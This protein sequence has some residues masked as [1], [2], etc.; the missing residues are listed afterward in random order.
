M[1]KYIK[2]LI[3]I[4]PIFFVMSCKHRKSREE[5]QRRINDSEITIYSNKDINDLI[6]NDYIYVDYTQKSI[7]DHKGF[8]DNNYEPHIT[9]FENSLN[10]I[11]CKNLFPVKVNCFQIINENVEFNYIMTGT[12]YGCHK[13]SLQCA[14]K[15]VETET[16]IY[17][18]SVKKDI[19]EKKN[20][21]I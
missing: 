19:E 10:R 13:Y 8:F 1:K 6:L 7:D 2:F 3:I 16:K 15:H 4:S 9:G 11:E 14:A 5:G 12:F 21:A 18:F 20:E 17:K